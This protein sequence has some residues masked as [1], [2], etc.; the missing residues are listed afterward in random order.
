VTGCKLTDH[1]HN[2][3]KIH[4]LEERIQDYENKCHNHM[5]RMDSLRLTQKLRITNQT[6][7]EMLDDR[8]DVGRMVYGTEQ[9]S[10]GIP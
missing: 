4:D 1:V 7:E 2:T 10:K 3:L 8:E 6:D 9:A 5:L